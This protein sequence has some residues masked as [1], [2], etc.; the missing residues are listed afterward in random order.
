MLSFRFMAEGARQGENGVYVSFCEEK[1]TLAQNLTSE[2]HS[3]QEME[4]KDLVT[5]MDLLTVR[6]GGLT[7][8]FDLIFDKIEEVNAKRLVIDSYSVVSQTFDEKINARIMLHTILR[9]ILRELG[10]TTVIISE[11]EDIHNSMEAYVSDAIL[12]L[13]KKELN[14]RQ[15]REMEIVKM[16]GTSVSQHKLIFTLDGGFH[17]I[18]P[19][20]RAA[21]TV[22]SE[23][24]QKNYL[25]SSDFFSEKEILIELGYDIQPIIPLLIFMPLAVSALKQGH[26]VLVVSSTG[27]DL[28]DVTRILT[29][30]VGKEILRSHVRIAVPEDKVERKEDW[31]LPMR[32]SIQDLRPTL[33]DWK[34]SGDQYV[35]FSDN[36]HLT[37]PGMSEG[38]LENVLKNGEIKTPELNFRVTR[39]HWK[40]PSFACNGSFYRVRQVNGSVVLYGVKPYTGLYGLELDLDKF[41]DTRL[42]PIN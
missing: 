28:S 8:T 40:L 30:T 36:D 29:S 20:S 21:H 1:A 39:P 35:L 27:V 17:V 4:E 37:L 26:K 7:T 33:S 2:G 3:F 19:F 11:G 16:R 22:G 41:V 23:I 9:K 13:R 10:C 12:L 34:S 25:S 5:I 32:Q 15:I 6:E 38:R 18:R 31:I 24:W 14:G 42:I